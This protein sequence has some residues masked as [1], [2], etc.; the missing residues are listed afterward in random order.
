L[1]PAHQQ[2]FRPSFEAIKKKNPAT[3]G[4]QCGL[5]LTWDDMKKS[6][7]VDLPTN[8]SVLGAAM[9]QESLM[10]GDKKL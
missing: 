10:R 4:I 6:C 7:K 3:F 9:G 1:Q 5:V 2:R 8:Q